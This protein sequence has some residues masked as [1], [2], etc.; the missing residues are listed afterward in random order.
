MKEP[1]LKSVMT[2]FPYSIEST[3]SLAEAREMMQVHEVRHLPVTST[4][5]LKGVLDINDLDDRS[6]RG[7]R[8]SDTDRTTVEVVLA[9]RPYYSVDLDQP[10]HA[11]LRAMAEQHL[12][13]ALIT[14]HGRL[15][16]IFTAT[17]ACRAFA[18]HL[19]RQFRPGE[20][21][22]PEAA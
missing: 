10:L 3:A 2:P 9:E 1:L 15:A 5:Q 7:G 11:V 13:A 21:E 20:D 4:H 12:S 14:T 22:P 8:H 18:G 17:D 6:G 19:D 16:G